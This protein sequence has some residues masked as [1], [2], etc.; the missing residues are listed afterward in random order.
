MNEPYAQTPQSKAEI[1]G[2]TGAERRVS[3]RSGE[4]LRKLVL[5][6]WLAT[7]AAAACLYWTH[8]VSL[9]SE[10]TQALSLSAL[11]GAAVYVFSSCVRGF[12]LIPST[13]LLVA[14]LPFF[15]PLSLY[16][17]T[18]LGVAV[19]ASS[20]YYFS[21]AMGIDRL[22]ETKHAS[23][24]AKL[25]DVLHRNQFGIVVGWSFFPFVPTDLICYACGTMRTGFRRFLLAVLVGE[26]VICAAYIFLGERL[27]D[28]LQLR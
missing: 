4:R 1:D 25:K 26:G 27:L 8:R 14:G 7:V 10:L 5:W 24:L 15:S 20:V 16:A 9:Q 28:L 6:V 22:F 12:T 18:M 23:R 13:F 11:V 19:S 21:H 2:D 17:M 3:G